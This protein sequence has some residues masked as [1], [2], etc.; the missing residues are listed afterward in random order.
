MAIPKSG[1]DMSPAQMTPMGKSYY[2][3]SQ[4]QHVQVQLCYNSIFLIMPNASIVESS[5]CLMWKY[6]SERCFLSYSGFTEDQTDE[7]VRLIFVCIHFSLNSNVKKE[8][9]V[10]VSNKFTLCT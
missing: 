7:M 5:A 10:Q 3:I 2:F 8:L 9:Q 1:G 4:L 6:N